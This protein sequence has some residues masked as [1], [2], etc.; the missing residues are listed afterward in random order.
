MLFN[1]FETFQNFR[2]K[3]KKNCQNSLYN[4]S[5]NFQNLELVFT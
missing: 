2:K 3:E 4:M 1:I 5:Y